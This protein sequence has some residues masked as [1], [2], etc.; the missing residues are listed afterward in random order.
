MA[1]IKKNAALLAL[2]QAALALPGIARAGDVQTDY[3]YS[4]YREA[5]IPGSRT[6]SGNDASRYDIQSHKFRVVKPWDDDVLGLNLTVETM[7]G[8]SPWYITPGVDGRPLQVMSGASIEED[9]V[10]VNGTWAMP[11]ADTQTAFSLGV[12]H[13]EDYQS[14]NG[15]VETEF[16]NADKSMTWTAGVG[17]SSDEIDPTT[18]P[19]SPVVID[20]AS[21][22]SGSLFGG[23]ALVLNRDAVLQFGASY[24]R[25]DGYLSDP[26]KLAWVTDLANTVP[27]ARP[28]T[29][30][31]WIA[32][33][34]FRQHFDGP[35]A[36]LAVDYRFYHD[37]W[38][39]NAHSIDLAWHQLLPQNWRLSPG[40]RW[41][42][43]SQAYFYAPW[44]DTSRSD[45][46]ASSD[47]RLSPFG[48]LSY[49]VDVSKTMGA[50]SLGAGVESYEAKG[51]YAL[52]E[53]S[54]ENPGLV[55]YLNWQLRVSYRF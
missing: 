50:L 39:I 38:K 43:Q 22:T 29:R 28:S 19:S 42:S 33:A 34:K 53:V 24:Q 15:G 45:G 12:S 48:A 16:S 36:A 46:Y 54:V 3:M 37:D 47:Y 9:R 30:D 13:E 25:N 35:Q 23:L 11:L 32:T 4:N 6:T 27:D 7:S 41:Y 18:G 1:A 17:F 26:Y 20:S 44:Y 55:E 31:A 52:K 10:A 8:A 51:S 40:V 21:K 5:D 49:R 14:I 2:T